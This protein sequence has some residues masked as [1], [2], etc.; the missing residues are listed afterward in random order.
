MANKRS[1]QFYLIK[2]PQLENNGH[3]QKSAKR[4][5]PTINKLTLDVCIFHVQRFQIIVFC[6]YAIKA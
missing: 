1:V 6:I 3:L 5:T 2:T 4:L